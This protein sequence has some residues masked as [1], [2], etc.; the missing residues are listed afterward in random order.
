MK[1]LYISFLLVSFSLSS[2]VAQKKLV[3]YAITSG[4]P[5]QAAWTEVNKVDLQSGEVI[6]PVFVKETTGF[7]VLSARNGKVL[8]VKEAVNGKI[9][10]NGQLPFS[11]FAAAC[12]YDARHNRLYYTPM[13]INQLRYIDLN[14]K[15]PRVYYFDGEN[16]SKAKNLN[17]PANHITR[18]VIGADGNGYALSNDANHLI[19][20]STGKT[21]VITDL[22]ALSDAATNTD[23]SIHNQCTSWGGDMVAAAD[24][25]L[26]IVSANQSIFRVDI[27]KMEAQFV[28]KI[29]GLPAGFTTNG[30]V[31]SDEGK[32]VVGSANTDD[33]FYQVDMRNWSA[34]KVASAK[35]SFRTS[36]LANGNLAF[37]QEKKAETLPLLSRV[38]ATKNGIA[39][40]PNPVA[41]GMFRVSFNLEQKG[42]YEV[43][44]VDLTGR[45]L[46]QKTM[47]ITYPGQVADFVLSKPVTNGTYMLK[48]VTEGAKTIQTEKLII[49]Q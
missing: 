13:Y 24:G 34:A 23:I 1:Y 37:D 35:G 39:I 16:L 10:D 46:M 28:A 40:Y 32:L 47:A 15:E 12:A 2:V 8:P 4:V 9:T 26:Y 43:Q 6:K 38:P 45:I 27:A 48:V 3:A 14:A 25:S 33:G 30:A 7:E 36:D 5:G 17:E 21:P 19:R 31:V 29:K 22:G 42:K 44:L 20:F 49:Q 11:S 18:M 41:E